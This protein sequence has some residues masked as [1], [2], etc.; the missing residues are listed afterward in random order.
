[1]IHAKSI[2]FVWLAII[3]LTAC[4]PIE[5]QGQDLRITH[6]PT[7]DTIEL[8]LVYHHVT[9]PASSSQKGGR[10]QTQRGFEDLLKAVATVERMSG[11]EKLFIPLAP[12]F[13]FDLDDEADELRAQLQTDQPGEAQSY[14][15]MIERI[16]IVTAQVSKDEKGHVKIH[17]TIRFDGAKKF[18]AELNKA[19]RDGFLLWVAESEHPSNGSES[20]LDPETIKAWNEEASAGKNWLRWEGTTLIASVP[21]TPGSTA[22]LLHSTY[23]ELAREPEESARIGMA[24]LFALVSEIHTDDGR[25]TIHLA[26]NDQNSLIFSIPGNDREYRPNLV[27]ALEA[28][29]FPFH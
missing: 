9:A 20:L 26:P 24:R 18:T 11:G 22:R 7:A 29:G 1:M 23:L 6:D 14:L 15:D 21:M 2:A 16:S 8:D 28:K 10:A 3:A 27:D 19:L 17:Q 12:I 4:S 5:F 25:L 13:L